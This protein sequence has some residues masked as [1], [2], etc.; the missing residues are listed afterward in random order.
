MKWNHKN[1]RSKQS[2]FS[3]LSFLSLSLLR[4]HQHFLLV[5]CYFLSSL[6]S[7]SVLFPTSFLSLMQLGSYISYAF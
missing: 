7:F 6:S 5:F 3:F 2:L 1:G 4:S